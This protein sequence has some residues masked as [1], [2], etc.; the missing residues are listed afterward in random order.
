M[1]CFE[2]HAQSKWDCDIE[3]SK[4]TKTNIQQT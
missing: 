1:E 2:G 3:R 4:E